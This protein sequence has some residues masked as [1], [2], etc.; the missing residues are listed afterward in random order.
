V[1]IKD[2]QKTFHQTAVD[3]GFH[4]DRQKVPSEYYIASKLA[5]ISSEVSEALEDVRKNNMA[6]V[7]DQN[8]KPC[9]LP[10]ELADVIIRVLDLAE[11]LAID[12]EAVLIAKHNYNK[13]RSYRHGNKTL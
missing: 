2:L 10:S 11:Y 8:G 4:D 12:M 1:D 7:T 9:G 13:T 6:F 3:H 5:L